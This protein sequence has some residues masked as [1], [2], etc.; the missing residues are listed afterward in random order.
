MKKKLFGITPSLIL[1][2]SV[3][4]AFAAETLIV[5]GAAASS[6]PFVGQII[7]GKMRE[8]YYGD[9]KNQVNGIAYSKQCNVAVVVGDAIDVYNFSSGEGERANAYLTDRLWDVASAT[10]NGKPIFVAVG[11]KSNILSSPDCGKT[12]KQAIPYS[13][14]NK[15]GGKENIQKYQNAIKTLQAEVFGKDYAMGFAHY[16]GV[17]FVDDGKG[18]GKFIAT[19]S[20]DAAATLKLDKDGYL[21]FESFSKNTPSNRDQAKDIVPTGDG[22]YMIVGKDSYSCDAANQCNKLRGLKKYDFESGIKDGDLTILGGNFSQIAYNTSGTKQWSLAKI[23]G[24][25]NVIWNIRKCGGQYY[26]AVHT[27]NQLVSSPDGKTWN[28]IN[29]KHHADNAEGYRMQIKGITCISDGK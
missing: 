21:R 8:L 13:E 23:S 28:S 10:V 2:L 17:E 14:E 24:R 7:D 20:F 27:A 1:A 6:N 5:G 9:S 18:S 12:W 29:L 11:N 3:G 15:I 16:R 19:G 22:S 26:G 4:N 25:P